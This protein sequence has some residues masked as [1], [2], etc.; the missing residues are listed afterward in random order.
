[1][2]EEENKPDLSTQFKVGNKAWKA[3]SSHGRKPIFETEE[4]LWDACCEYFQWVNDNPLQTVEL[5][6]FQGDAK[7]VQ[8]PVMRNMSLDGLQI[9]LDISDQTWLNYKKKTD[10]L[11]VTEQIDKIIRTYK[12]DGAIS[13]FFKENIIARELGLADKKEVET[14]DKYESSFMQKLN[15]ALKKHD[16]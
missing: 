6:K 11:G 15:K 7:Q 1:M 4:Q 8:V 12:M 2:S 3:R 10:F 9:F 16:D 5:A 14:S 13:G